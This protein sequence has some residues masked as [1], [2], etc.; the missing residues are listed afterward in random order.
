M[1]YRT[2]DAG[3]LSRARRWPRWLSLTVILVVAVPVA[4]LILLTFTLDA[5]LA[6]SVRAF[7]RSISL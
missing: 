1:A 7:R 2:A 4:L 3:K 6:S 5:E